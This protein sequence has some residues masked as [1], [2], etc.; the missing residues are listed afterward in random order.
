M[1]KQEKILSIAKEALQKIHDE[2]GVVCHEYTVCDHAT[3]QSSYT[4]WAIAT[5]AIE[6]I[7]KLEEN[8]GT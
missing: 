6:E 4:S 7:R 2:E 1:N 8:N 5:Q 3:C